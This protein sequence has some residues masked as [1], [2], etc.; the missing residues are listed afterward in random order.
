VTGRAAFL[1][2]SV[3]ISQQFA[4]CCWPS[5]CDGKFHVKWDILWFTLRD[6]Y[7]YCCKVGRLSVELRP[8]KDSLS[9]PDE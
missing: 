5:C 7:R 2:T 6:N 9:G 4:R 3:V 8:L 1:P